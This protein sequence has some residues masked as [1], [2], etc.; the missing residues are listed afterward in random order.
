MKHIVRLILVISLCF[1]VVFVLSLILKLLQI[2][3]E[4]VRA[5]PVFS[6][7][8][9]EE[10][11]AAARGAF[12]ITIYFSILL[13]VSYTARRGIPAPAAIMC[14]IILGMSA[15]LLIALGINALERIPPSPS[16]PLGIPLG[17]AGLIFS[18]PPDKARIFLEDPG[19]PQGAQVAAEPDRP[20]LYEKS[21]GNAGGLGTAQGFGF[22]PALLQSNMYFFL[23]RI[24]K[25]IDLAAAQFTTRFKEGFML[26][27]LYMLSL[28]FLL[29]SGRFLMDISGWPLANLF[30]GILAFRGVLALERVL[31]SEGTWTLLVSFMG[32]GFPQWVLSPLVFVC[33]GSVVILYAAFARLGKSRRLD[34][35]F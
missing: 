29:S 14:L 10:C 17:E 35:D 21:P 15:S 32:E 2:R 30:L 9:L 27:F 22:A 11:I 1:A 16:P 19:N 23:Q 28:V 3:L 7:L 12:P 4:S 25:D 13:S 6:R 18:H 34:E 26:F 24:F 5:L 33:L 31:N 20:L 8:S